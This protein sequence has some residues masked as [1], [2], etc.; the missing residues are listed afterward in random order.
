MILELT[1]AQKAFQ[2]SIQQF[3]REIVAQRAAGIDKSGEYPTDVMHAATDAANQKTM[4]VR[5]GDRYRITGRKVW[6][7]NAE[8]AS[9]AILFARTR[10]GLRGQGIT[11]FLAPMDTSGIRRTA[12]AD[13]LGVRGLGC[14]D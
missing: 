8:E 2:T 5:A 1:D 12:R 3:A 14:M 10:P 6:V 7:A 9:V 11:A 13:S 4:A